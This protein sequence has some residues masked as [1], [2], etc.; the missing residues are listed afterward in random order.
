MDL[1]DQVEFAKSPTGLDILIPIPDKI[2]LLRDEIFTTGG[3]AGPAA[4]DKDAAVLMKAENARVSVKMA[5]RPLAWR[6]KPP[7]TSKI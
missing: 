2:R 1:P 4:V 3:P 7:I 6:H 5:V